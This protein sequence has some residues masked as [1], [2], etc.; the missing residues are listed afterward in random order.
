MRMKACS[1][2]GA[3]LLAA[4]TT[5]ADGTQSV[6][7]TAVGAGVGAIAGGVLGNRLDKGNRVRGTVIGAAAGTAAGAGIGYLMD[8]QEAELREQ[9]AS[10]RTDHAIE[11]ERV[12]DDLLKLTLANEISFDF[13]SAAIKPAFKPT[14]YKLAEVLK[15]YDRNEITIIGHTDAV[16]SDSYNQRALGAA[17]RGGARGADGARRSAEPPARIGRGESSRAPTTAARPAASSIG[18]SRSW[19]RPRP[20]DGGRHAN[21]SSAARSA[22]PDHGSLGR[23]RLIE[24]RGAAT[25]A[26]RSP[27]SVGAM[28]PPL[29]S[30]RDATVRLGA[31]PLFAALSVAVAAGD[32]ICLVGRNG[33]GKSTLLKTLAG[34]VELDAGERFQRPGAAV[35][36]LPQEPRLDPAASALE[37][38]LDGLAQR[39]EAE[40]AGH[41]AA[42][43]LERFAI[44]PER[45]IGDLSG[46]EARR[47]DLARAM[48]GGPT[49]SCSTSRPTISTCRPSSASRRISRAWRGGLVLVSH[50]RAFLAPSAARPG[51]SIAAGS[52]PST[53]ALPRSTPGPSRS[54][55]RKKPTC[56]D[57]TRHRG[58]DRMVAPRHHRPAPAQPGPA[59][60]AS[61]P[62][63]G[64]GTTD[65]AAR[66]GQARGRKPRRQRRPAGD[67][68][69]GHRQALR[70]ACADR[71]TSRPGSCVG[72]GSGS[73]ARTAV[74]R[75]RSC[76]C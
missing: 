42:A 56:A 68:G 65:R 59:A 5:H 25:V 32:R 11:L 38:T 40:V 17:G 4:C 19:C 26:P 62:A 16:G 1:A 53:R 22:A 45:R 60:A 28:I 30:L 67:R 49:C 6:N 15:K 29:L 3:L 75:P 44:A 39:G 8:R 36:Y 51:G 73:S 50:D 54:S 13:G 10:E 58:R 35:A 71:G 41:R 64:T 76:V 27:H 63:R 23:R 14:M 72:I 61:G 33:A 24:R 57:W 70:R 46:G 37:A 21:R 48:V 69:Q 52:A 18:A 31:E 66:P 2:L 34:L 55:R 74:A 47:V 9:L 20:D 7:K 12:R 43:V